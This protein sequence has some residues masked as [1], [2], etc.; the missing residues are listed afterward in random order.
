MSLIKLENVSKYYKSGEGVSVGMKNISLE[1]HNN[2]FIVVT[3]ESGSGKSTLLNVI[4]G[5]DTY[6]DGEMY[7]LGEE[8]SHFT[9]KD[10]ENY[11]SKYVGFIFQNYNI[12]DSYTVYENVI[13]ALEIQNYP[14]K[15][16]KK[17]A[18]EL[19]EKVGLLTHKNHKAAKLSGGQKQRVAI[20]RALAKD[21]PII[22]ADEPTGNLDS[23]SS[24]QIIKLLKEVSSDRL[25]VL[26][27]HDPLIAKSTGTR[28]IKLHDGE[29]IEDKVLVKKEET[30]VKEIDTAK[31]SYFTLMR[32]ALRNI[33]SMPK[34]LIFFTLLQ[35]TIITVFILTYISMMQTA[36]NIKFSFSM[37]GNNSSLFDFNTQFMSDQRMYVTRKDGKDLTATDYAYFDSLNGDHYVY[38]NILNIDEN[39][40]LILQNESNYVLYDIMIDTTFAVGNRVQFVEGNMPVNPYDILVSEGMD[41]KIGDKVKVNQKVADIYSSY[42]VRNGD[43]WSIPGVNIGSNQVLNYYVYTNYGVEF[44]DYNIIYPFDPLHYGMNPDDINNVEVLYMD[45]EYTPMELI[46]TG[47][48]KDN[49]RQAIY[50]NHN[51]YENLDYGNSFMIQTTSK[52]ELQRIYNQID[53]SIYRIISPK[54]EDS[55]LSSLVAPLIFLF[56]L[57][58]YIIVLVIGVFLYFILY[59]VTKN[60]MHARKKDFA[61]F[62][63]IGATQ[64]QL[65]W[66]VIFEQF[67]MMNMAFIASVILTQIISIYNFNINTMIRTLTYIDYIILFITFTYLSTRLA[68]KFNKKT[69]KLSIIENI[70]ESK[71]EMS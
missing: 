14:K 67:F 11:R 16:R 52:I 17:R 50:I 24:D 23:E 62:R 41:L 35:I 26:V 25:V 20:A 70:T 64:K 12:I 37:G 48:F 36:E 10:W 7:I 27:T 68:Q 18:L 21:T 3:G 60:I 47:I 6:E 5:I 1:F 59:S 65:G 19:I 66:V 57:F 29:V 31:T 49:Y 63:T 28:L 55:A 45:A 56:R 30:E 46:V 4:S 33:L 71:E 43:Y 58:F 40:N 32:F 38:K 15:L 61:I 42:L 2:E 8:T 9:A 44:I 69:F 51:T 34:R 54:L 39:K 53:R 22:I 13:L